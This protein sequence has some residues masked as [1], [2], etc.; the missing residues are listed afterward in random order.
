VA[1]RLAHLPP[2]KGDPVEDGKLNFAQDIAYDTS[3][4]RNELGYREEVTY[5]EGLRR[6]LV[7]P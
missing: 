4:I 6:T 1:E 7:S 2:S 3:R 5:E